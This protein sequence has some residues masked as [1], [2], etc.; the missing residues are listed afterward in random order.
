MQSRAR[1]LLLEDDIIINISTTEQ[2]Q[3]LGYTV[4]PAEHLATAW[5][6]VKDELPD[7]AVL[8]VN[9]DDRDTSLELAEWLDLQRVPIVFLTGYNSPAISGKWRDHAICRKPCIAKELNVLLIKALSKHP[10]VDVNAP[11]RP[12]NNGR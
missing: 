12:S 4:W 11:A 7:A 10:P 5:K 8:D 2:L 6:L 9:I 3:E 1:I